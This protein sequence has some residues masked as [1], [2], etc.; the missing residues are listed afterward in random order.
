LVKNGTETLD[1]KL[2]KET[3]G[4]RAGSKAWHGDFEN[5]HYFGP[6]SATEVLNGR[7]IKKWPFRA[8]RSLGLLT[9]WHLDPSSHRRHL[10][11]F[12]FAAA[13]HGAEDGERAGSRVVLKQSL[14]ES[15]PASP[16]FEG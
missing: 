10:I 3:Q 1:C 15:G 11:S 9:F 12:I 5:L 14:E 4:T 16:V 7:G 2:S 6:G 8:I 13:F